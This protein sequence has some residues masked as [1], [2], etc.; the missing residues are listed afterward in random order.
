MTQ[1]TENT[2]KRRAF[3]EFLGQ[4]D[5]IQARRFAALDPGGREIAETGIKRHLQAC[6]R[7]EVGVD[8]SALREIID[9]AQNGRRVYAEL[10]DGSETVVSLLPAAEKL[11]EKPAR[12]KSSRGGKA[13][14]KRSKR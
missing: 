4:I 10:P 5:F 14:R 3:A 11:G 9:D 13:V 12:I 7:M 8:I 2:P 6:R 1:R